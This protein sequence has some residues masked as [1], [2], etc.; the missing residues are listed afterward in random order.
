MFL[1]FAA[2]A[3]PVTLETFM[4]RAGYH[5]VRLQ[6][7]DFQL[8]AKGTLDGRP[9]TMLVDSGCSLTT[10]NLRQGQH[11]P[12]LG[13]LG[14]RITACLVPSITE[15]LFALGLGDAV[16]LNQR[17]RVWSL[18]LGGPGEFG[19]LLGCDFLFRNHC[20][21][22]PAGRMLLVRGTSPPPEVE[23]ALLGSLRQSGFVEVPLTVSEELLF[24]I[25][26]E[27]A[28]KAVKLCVDTGAF[29]TALDR[30]VARRLKLGTEPTRLA[31][32]G[33]GGRRVERVE[34]AR[35]ESFRLGGVEF[36]RVG[37]MVFELEKWGVGEEA[38]HA[39]DFHGLLGLPW[40]LQQRVILDYHG[41]RIWLY[42][43]AGRRP[44]R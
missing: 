36:G 13:T 5:P 11:L 35:V 37:L 18:K 19:A 25:E 44:G 15:L 3:E 40:M 10:V 38:T 16:F 9:A 28:G 7:R 21:L 2:G 41:K 22:D 14:A 39:H 1:A 17:V 33:V 31:A 26:A 24:L 6:E 8:L 20:V 32:R 12:D 43:D 42:P 23:A 27:V 30:D 34:F 4:R 29:F